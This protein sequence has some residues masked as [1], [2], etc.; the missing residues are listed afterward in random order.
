MKVWCGNLTQSATHALVM[1]QLYVGGRCEGIHGFVI[2]VRDEKTHRALPGIRIGDMGE[3]PGQWN[4]VENGWM[5]FED[6][7]C[8]VDALLNRGC[9]ITSDGRYVTAFKSARERTS[10]TLVAL[11]MGRV[12][13]IGKGVQALR[14]AATIGIRY[15]AV[16]K[17]FGPANGDELPILSYPLQRRRLLPS[18]AAA[19]SIG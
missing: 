17:Q 6:Y 3:K 16:R 11:S 14:N 10:V 9:E 1:A 5:M 19:I 18:L 8:S 13:I 15:S 12:G 7:R 2:Q 4:G